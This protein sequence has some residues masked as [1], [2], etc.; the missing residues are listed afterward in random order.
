M[1]RSKFSSSGCATAGLFGIPTVGFG[2]ADELHS[3]TVNDQIPLAQLQPAMAF[4][5]MFPEM[6]QAASPDRE[7][8]PPSR[9]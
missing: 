8:L 6:Y 3:H 4:Y 2:P 7:S 9:S 5:A 1:H